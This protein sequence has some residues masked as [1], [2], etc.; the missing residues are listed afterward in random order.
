M[1]Q[2]ILKIIIYNNYRL[3]RWKYKYI[4]LIWCNSH[5]SSLN[6]LGDMRSSN[7]IAKNDILLLYCNII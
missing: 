6:I 2:N 7:V 3:E 4:A 5:Q 1:D